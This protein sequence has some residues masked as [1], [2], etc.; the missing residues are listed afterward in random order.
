MVGAMAVDEELLGLI[1]SIYDAAIDDSLWP[2]TMDRLIAV[3]DSQAASFCILDSSDDQPRLSTFVQVNFRRDHIQEYLDYMTPH[4]PTIQHIVARPEQKIHHDSSFITEREKDRHA[5]Y[6][7]HH[8]FSDTRHRIAGIIHPARGIQSGVTIHRTRGKGDFDAEM[9]RRFT[10]LFSHIERALQIGFRLGTLGNV[11]Q[12][13]LA[14]LD[15]N[16]L[17]IVLLDQSGR[18][19]LA[20]RAARDLAESADGVTLGHNALALVRRPDDAVLQRLIGA[21]LKMRSQSGAYPGGTMSALRPSGK[22]PF[23]IMVSPLSPNAFAMTTVQP[24]VCVVIADPEMRALPPAERLSALYGLTP[25]EARLAMRLALGEDLRAAAEAIGIRYS[26]A[27]TQLAAIF[28][29]T[30]TSRQGELVRLL[31]TLLPFVD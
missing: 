11:Q 30:E 31:M 13:S 5:Y 26:T 27:R 16:P 14:M 17:A 3:T 24:A 7:W 19:V 6:D 1:A 20:N 9:S 12:A 28:R 8:R 10:M 2:E 21:A 15:R 29:K 4:D 23:S 22:R 25:S 18:V